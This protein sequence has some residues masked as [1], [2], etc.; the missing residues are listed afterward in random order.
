MCD[1]R[2]CSTCGTAIPAL[3]PDGHCPACLLRIGLGLGRQAPAPDTPASPLERIRYLGDYELLEQIASGGMGVVFRARQLSL[4]RLVAV[5][6]IRAGQFAN[7]TDVARF[8]REAEDA[9]QLDHPNIVPIYEVGEHHGQHYFSMKL[10]E[11]GSLA[12]R[13]ARP[14]SP[15]PLRD[16]AKLMVRIGRAVHYAHQRGILH[17]DLKP[18]N[19]LLDVDGLPQVSDFGLAG[20]VE[21][22]SLMTLSGAI[23]GTPAY[24]APE[25][26]AG[27]KPLTT[28]V[29][30]HS[31]GA[32][33]YEMLTGQPPF[34]GASV[35][36]TLMQVRDAAPVPPR[37]CNPRVPRDL[38]TICL[39]CLEKDPDHRYAS[40]DALAEDLERWLD[41]RPIR[42][43]PVTPLVRV[44]KWMRRKPALATVVV[45]LHLVAALGAAGVLWQWR[46]AVA[47]KVAAQEALREKEEQVWLAS[48]NQARA[49]RLTGLLGARQRAL[50]AITNAAR[51]RASDTALRNEAIAALSMTDLEP[52]IIHSNAAGANSWVA[53]DPVH[54]RTAMANQAGD[55]IL[56]HLDTGA[57][58]F[59]LHSKGSGVA[60]HAFSP[61]GRWLAAAL[62][63]GRV[64]LW[65]PEA[66]TARWEHRLETRAPEGDAF[67]FHPVHPWLAVRSDTNRLL[68]LRLSDGQAVQT[69]T[70]PWRPQLHRFSPDGR[71]LALALEDR[72]AI[73]DIAQAALVREVT[74]RSEVSELAWHPAGR[75]LA[76]GGSNGEILWWHL[77]TGRQEPWQGEPQLVATLDFDPSGKRLITGH[78]NYISQLWDVATGTRLLTHRDSMAMRFD[79]GGS[80]VALM[81]PDNRHGLWRVT[82]TPHLCTLSLPGEMPRLFDLAWS[83]DGRWIAVVHTNGLA[84]AEILPS[85][86]GPSAGRQPLAQETGGQTDADASESRTRFDPVPSPEARWVSERHAPGCGYR[87]TFARDGRSI[88]TCSEQPLD[89]EHRFWRWPLSFR[90]ETNPPAI[91]PPE[92]VLDP[93]PRPLEA[94]TGLNGLAHL[95]PTDLKYHFL[96][97]L[98]F[99]DVTAPEGLYELPGHTSSALS[100]SRTTNWIAQYHPQGIQIRRLA[101]QPLLIPGTLPQGLVLLSPDNRRLLHFVSGSVS[102][103]A[104]STGQLAW[105]RPC[106][107]AAT[108]FPTFSPD[109]QTLAV[110]GTSSAQV[111]LFD[112]VTGAELATLT[113]PV[114]SMI[115]GLAFSPDNQILAVSHGRHIALWDLRGLRRQLAGMGLDWAS[116]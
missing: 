73:W 69:I 9:A 55:L 38:E 8:R 14:L 5:K 70:L 108:M 27:R 78:W 59:R 39:K 15:M 25:Q 58:L 31:L 96:G 6:M 54:P 88:L 93:N 79:P 41:H 11:G 26:A 48:V 18:G 23:L 87:V 36:E 3:A 28:A 35:V 86:M 113:P 24:M 110:G 13:L 46:A 72:C 7:E 109:G 94:T 76:I 44:V 92:P 68:L 77:E 107:T 52:Q 85:V 105:R 82:G 99:V 98:R 80:R 60:S 34:R 75:Q 61:D 63:D 50:T 10:I 1:P 32:V 64:V 51:I 40:A 106:A 20:R 83:P 103:Y 90:G 57:G 100:L 56:N 47:A 19:I 21:S 49:E 4:N 91:G 102:G 16:A 45:A 116:L 101:G 112:P 66:R 30:I 22:D 17:R 81:L 74:N 33:L 29:D 67:T 95:F 97:A 43:L 42:A 84:L 115:G 53:I 104:T 111:W 2:T 12:T 89:G 65:D 114:N 71:Q 37:R 62:R